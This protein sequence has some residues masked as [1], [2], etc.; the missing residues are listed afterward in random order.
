[1]FQLAF[2]SLIT[3][4]GVSPTFGALTY[5]GFSCGYSVKSLQAI[6][7]ALDRQFVS[8]NYRESFFQNF[9]LVLALIF[10]PLIVS[11]VLWIVNKRKY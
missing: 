11:F 9:N 1:V 4:E 3:V 2:Y 10:L 8:L 5:L 7:T 6:Q